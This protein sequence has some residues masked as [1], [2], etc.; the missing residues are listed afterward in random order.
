MPEETPSEGPGAVSF[1]G[2][3]LLAKIR[4]YQFWRS[5]WANQYDAPG[6]VEKRRWI[7]EHRFSHALNYTMVLTGP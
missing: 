5:R 3:L 6:V 1:S 4:L 2:F 7:S